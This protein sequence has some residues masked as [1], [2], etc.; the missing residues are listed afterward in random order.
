MIGVNSRRKVSSR[1][2]NG[3]VL[4]SAS[5][6]AGRPALRHPHQR[7]EVAEEAAQ[8]G[9]Q[10]VEVLERRRELARRRAELVDQRVGVLGERGQTAWW[11][12]GPRA[13][14]SG[15]TRKVSASWASR[16]AVV[17]HTRF[18]FRISAAQ[19][20][21]ALGQGAEDLAGVAHQP[22]GGP[23]LGPQDLQHVVGVLGERGEV[24]ERVV[25]RLAVAG[26]RPALLVEPGGEA[27]ARLRVER[28][29]DLVELH[30]V[31]HLAARQAAAVRHRVLG[32]RPPGCPGRA[33]RRSRPSS[34]FWR[35]IAAR[36]LGDRRVARVDLHHRVA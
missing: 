24:A 14:R 21:A 8:V 29:K 32:C 7:A 34:V 1:P 35:S 13:G 22:P 26:G 17:S 10:L 4:L 20:A 19:L 30:G 27:L 18:E 33:R 5:E 3:R 2:R 12:C 9:R 36:V 6:V 31:R 16:R 23:A 25:D 15:S 28:A 11:S